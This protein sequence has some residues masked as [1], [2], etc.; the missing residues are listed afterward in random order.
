MKTF[1]ELQAQWENQKNVEVPENGAK[2]I[3][4]ILTNIRKQQRWTNGILSATAM[5]LIAFFFYVSAYKFQTVMIGL[6]L[7]IGA[8]FVRIAIEVHSLRRL[9]SMDPLKE[10]RAYKEQIIRYYH[11]RRRVHLVAT[12]LIILIYSYGFWLLLP[13]FKSSLSTGFYYYIIGSSL[14]IL[15]VLGFLIGTQIRKE[16]RILAR[17]KE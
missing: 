17:L 2:Q 9:R 16:L 4:T 3:I 6:F 15:V 1:K 13:S 12:P 11:R 14:V 8:L 10:A 7:M 5:I